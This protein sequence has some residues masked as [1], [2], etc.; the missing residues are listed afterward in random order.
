MNQLKKLLLITRMVLFRW[1]LMY[2]HTSSIHVT[3]N[4]WFLINTEIDLP[5]EKLSEV[6]REHKSCVDRFS[7]KHSLN[8][9]LNDW[10]NQVWLH[11]SV[12]RETKLFLSKLSW[13]IFIQKN[14]FRLGSMAMITFHHV[15]QGLLLYVDQCRIY[16]V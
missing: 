4:A 11:Q 16:N 6:R 8:C 15:K 14:I 13:I 12:T 2:W 5:W 1:N 7:K 3:L 9:V 10:K